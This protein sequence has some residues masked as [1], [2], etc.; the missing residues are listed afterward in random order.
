ME[1]INI[2]LPR[3]DERSKSISVCQKNT[4]SGAE[5]VFLVLCRSSDSRNLGSLVI[6]LG[7]ADGLALFRFGVA[8]GNALGDAGIVG[9]CPPIEHPFTDPRATFLAGHAN[10]IA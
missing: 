7:Q 3:P 4:L 5:L 10:S 2:D 8:D 9:R 1:R 6:L